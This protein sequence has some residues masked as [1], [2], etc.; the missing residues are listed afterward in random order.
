MLPIFI[1]KHSS[2]TSLIYTDQQSCGRD[3]VLQISMFTS[4]HEMPED[5]TTKYLWVTG[6]GRKGVK[7][8]SSSVQVNISACLF[9]LS[10]EKIID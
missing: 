5:C 8:S 9:S 2:R 4:K 7:P 10:S 6:G 3:W 1:V